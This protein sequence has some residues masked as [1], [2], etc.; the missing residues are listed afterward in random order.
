[1]DGM[2][3]K[4]CI[5]GFGEVAPPP[6]TYYGSYWGMATE[7]AD[8]ALKDAGLTKKDIDGVV[9]C[10]AY[11]PPLP[12]PSSNAAYFCE[13]TGLNPAWY[14]T[15]PYGGT[16]INGCLLRA[17]TGIEAGQA[18]TVLVIATDNFLSR[19]TRGG[20]VEAIATRATD[21]QYE[22]PYGGFTMT[23]LGMIAQRHMYEY[24]TTSEQMAAVAVS[25]RKWASLNP[26]AQ[27]REL[28]TVEDV[29]NSRLIASPLHLLDCSL[30]SDGGGA[31]VITTANRA[32]DF[33]NQPVFL[34]GLGE[35]GIGRY[36]PALPSLTD[37]NSFE[38]ATQKALKMARVGL[39]DID[40]VYTYDATTISTIFELEQMGF[41]KKG[42]GGSFVEGGRI[43]P[44]GELPVNT[45]GG[46]LACRHSTF[47]GGFFHVLEAVKQLRGECGERQ[48]KDA[49]LAIILSEGGWFNSN[50]TILGRV[51]P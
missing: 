15:Y 29:L 32:K 24:G 4:Y 9:F 8:R 35:W 47:C 1:M 14:E 26:I 18:N 40:M 41:C 21:S 28:I 10:S 49:K 5:V 50:A 11:G 48:V 20:G 17:A 42:E 12:A 16:P 51:V 7:A 46:L 23:H 43:E 3:G 2:R 19:L 30:I 37:I 6:K 31:V 27:M 38:I 13:Y 22:G 44:G 39:N 36:L 45:H 34:L 25:S 33:R